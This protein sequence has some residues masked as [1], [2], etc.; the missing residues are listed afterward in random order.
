MITME[1]ANPIAQP[2]APL[3]TEDWKKRFVPA[4]K[5]YVGTYGRH[6]ESLTIKEIAN[7]LNRQRRTVEGW[8]DGE[9]LP[10][11]TDLMNLIG[12]LPSGFGNW[13]LGAHGVGGLRDLTYSDVT[14]HDIAERTAG[15]SMSFIGWMDDNRIDHVEKAESVTLVRGLRDRCDRFLANIDSDRSAVMQVISGDGAR[16]A[17]AVQ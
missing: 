6:G 5:H 4:F 12:L 8:R 13:L 3:S 11:F 1:N 9:N 16:I 2:F 7:K 17:G 15:F 14:V 10:G